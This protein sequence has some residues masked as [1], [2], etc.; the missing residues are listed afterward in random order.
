MNEK[1][2]RKNVVNLRL[3]VER[4]YSQITRLIVSYDFM[5]NLK[6]AADL[7]EINNQTENETKQHNFQEVH[8]TYTEENEIW[9]LWGIPLTFSNSLAKD[10]IMEMRDGSTVVIEG[11]SG[12]KNK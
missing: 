3:I 9:F 8:A 5:L 10:A 11:I 12:Y 7:I 1:T 4:N 2:L 6:E